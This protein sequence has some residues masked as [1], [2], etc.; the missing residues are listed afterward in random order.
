MTGA[1]VHEA[2]AW[3]VV[4]ADAVRHIANA[5]NEG[6]GGPPPATVR[7]ILTALR[8]ELDAPTSEM[9]GGFAA[10]GSS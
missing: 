2:D 10:G 6:G 1:V 7:R 8:A 9:T 5:L 3:G 4:L